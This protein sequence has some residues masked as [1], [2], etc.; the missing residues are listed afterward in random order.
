V[1]IA[2]V[3]TNPFTNPA[4]VKM[5]VIGHHTFYKDKV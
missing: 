2:G 1:N 5:V 4:F 3:T